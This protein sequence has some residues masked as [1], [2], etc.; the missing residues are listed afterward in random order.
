MKVSTGSAFETTLGVPDHEHGV[1]IIGAGPAG[2]MLAVSRKRIGIKPLVIDSHLASEHE[3]GRGDGLMCRT[4]EVMQNLEVYDE[5]AKNST[6]LA[7]AAHWTISDNPSVRSIT[8]FVSPDM[9]IESVGLAI[10][11][12][13]VERIL[14][15]KIR[16]YY[17]DFEVLRPWT[18]QDASIED[19]GSQSFVNVT[20]CSTYGETRLIRT[21]YLVGCDGGK[22]QVRRVLCSK[23]GL[24][25]EGSSH[26]SLWAVIDVLSP[27][28]NFPDIKKF[29]VLETRC[30]TMMLLPREPVRDKECIRLYCPAPKNL[31]PNHEANIEDVIDMVHEALRPYTITWEEIN[32]F[33]IYR[34]GQRIAS[35]FD[36]KQKIFLAGDASHIHSPKAGLGMNT[37]MQD[38]HNLAFKLALAEKQIAKPDILATYDLERKPIAEQLLAM[39]EQLVE[40]FSKHSDA[41]K[42][43]S[44]NQGAA[45]QSTSELHRFQR[46]H[47]AYQAGVS[48]TYNE[49]VLVGPATG[50]PSAS[51]KSIG[52][53]GLVP[54]RRLLPA[55]V[56]RYIDGV[57]TPILDATLPFD[58]RFTIFLCLA[59]LLAQGNLQRIQ[60][61]KNYIMRPEGLWKRLNARCAPLGHVTSTTTNKLLPQSSTHPLFRFAAITTTEHASVPLASQYDD[62]FRSKDSVEPLL[63]GPEML[64]SDNIPAI[65]YGL[66]HSQGMQ[67]MKPTILMNPLHQK[68][69]VQ[70]EA[71]AIVVI[72]PD[73]HVGVVVQGLLGE[74]KFSERAW[75]TV[76]EYFSQFLL[77]DD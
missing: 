33:T 9:D 14:E 10:R 19:G 7:T 4:L 68:W 69:D 29:N 30:G 12:G 52:G 74:E 28:T 53:V 40:L 57:P 44:H 54:G 22:S 65:F 35:N 55:T 60:L 32:W 21:R 25:F 18:F 38:A 67:P 70:I 23:Y 15:E 36:V 62:L 13:L 34:V 41:L 16:E 3:F 50:G 75:K 48:I 73:G 49:N 2:M 11:Q 45:S 17:P 20:L 76:E 31:G 61:L 42:N 26:D 1:V 27:V 47:A 59:D 6:K 8:T 72:R 51:I 63:F 71:G 56:T 64:F 37:S 46:R 58:G 43:S 24:K 5:I 66:D 39:D 77:L